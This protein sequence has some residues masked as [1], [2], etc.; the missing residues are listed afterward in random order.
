MLALIAKG[1]TVIH[2]AE[3]RGVCQELLQELQSKHLKWRDVFNANAPVRTTE[4]HITDLPMSTIAKVRDGC[5]ACAMLEMCTPS[6]CS[7]P[8]E[9]VEE[10]RGCVISN[11]MLEMFEVGM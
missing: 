3:D 8:E 5:R 2:D 1:Y 7:L 4:R 9:P 11:T 6:R 10:K